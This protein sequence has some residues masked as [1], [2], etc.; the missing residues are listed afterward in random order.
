M[1]KVIKQLDKTIIDVARK[2]YIP[3]SRIAFFIIFFYFGALKL[4]GM[5]PATPLAA[6]LTQ[7][8]IGLQYFDVSFIVLAIIE[9]LIGVL[10]L[11]PKATRIVIPLLFVHL[12]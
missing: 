1:K 12:R 6:E 11:V 3:L 7:R 5:S 10:F 8:T 2:W 9:C 4:L